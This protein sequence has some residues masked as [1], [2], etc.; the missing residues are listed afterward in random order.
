MDIFGV[1]FEPGTVMSDQIIQI[2]GVAAG[3]CTSVSLIPQVVKIMKEKKAEDISLAYLLILFA[4]LALWIVYGGLRK[5]VPVI[6]TNVVS[7]I[8]NVTTI[9]LGIKYKRRPGK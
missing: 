3:V 4:G 6:A 7:V 8:V 9:V 5:D 2:V 1:F